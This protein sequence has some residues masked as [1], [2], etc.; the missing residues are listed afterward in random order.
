MEVKTVLLTQL[1]CSTKV[2]WE[3]LL[4]I[5]PS[6]KGRLAERSIDCEGQKSGWFTV[7]IMYAIVYKSIGPCTESPHTL[8]INTIVIKE[9][10]NSGNSPPSPNIHLKSDRVRA[11]QTS[12]CRRTRVSWRACIFS[13]SSS[14]CEEATSI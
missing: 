4:D 5:Y 1:H 13:P 6:L 12:A 10:T 11:S 8:V 7:I 2:L 9:Q 14:S 3:L